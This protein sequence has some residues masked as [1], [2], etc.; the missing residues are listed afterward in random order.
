[1]SSSARD[2]ENLLY[3]YAERLDL[4]DLEGMAKMFAHA[5]FVGP[6]GEVHG[7]GS[8]AIKDLYTS[9]VRLYTD[10]TPMTHHVTTN[11]II[12][13]DDD[14][15]TATSRSYFTVFQATDDLAL[16]PII[17]GR[18]HDD[19]KVVDGHWQFSRRQ[20]IPWLEGDLSHHQLVH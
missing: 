10:G 13:V 11:V 5:E 20:M 15:Q 4:G 14:E 1:V 9:Y 16:Q 19:F 17:A 8:D 18:Y 7:K 12:E 3:L 6:E 2:I